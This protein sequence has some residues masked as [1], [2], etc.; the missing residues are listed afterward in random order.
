MIP[1][2]YIS[3]W[4]ERVL[5]SEDFKVEQDLFISRALVAV[6]SGP[7]LAEALAFLGGTALY[8]LYLTP[9]ARCSEDIDFVQAEPGPVGPPLK[10]L[11]R[12]GSL[13]SLACCRRP[14]RIAQVF[15][16]RPTEGPSEI[17]KDAYVA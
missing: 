13:H 9:P 8:R 2:D 15:A 4:R 14:E 5:W 12:G 10:R 7:V 1:R 11:C 3:E 16:R 6:Y 17:Q